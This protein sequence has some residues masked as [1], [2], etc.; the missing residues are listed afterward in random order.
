METSPH[1]LIVDDDRDDHHLTRSL[2]GEVWESRYEFTHVRSFEEGVRTLAANNHDAC[3]ADYR[4]GEHTG[5]ELLQSARAQGC[6]IPILLLT[7]P[8]QSTC[9]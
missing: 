3:L 6:R 5:V 1:L 9:A 7:G 2:L 8:G 4:L